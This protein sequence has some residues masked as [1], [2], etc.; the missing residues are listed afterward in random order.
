MTACLENTIGKKLHLRF[1]KVL[2]QRKEH[3]VKC[4]M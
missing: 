3:L 2:A 4:V 1:Y